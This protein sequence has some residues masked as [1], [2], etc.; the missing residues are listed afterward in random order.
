MAIILRN[1]KGSELT[2]TEVDDNFSSLLFDVALSGNNLL[3]YTNNGA[4]VL[5][6]TIDLSGISA[7]SLTTSKNS[8]AIVNNGNVINTVIVNAVGKEFQANQEFT[9]TEATLQS[10]GFGGAS[11][12]YKGRIA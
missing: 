12:D 4:N 5:K 3:F 10:L 2:W 8:A 9:I 11:S 7:S 1:T 6:T